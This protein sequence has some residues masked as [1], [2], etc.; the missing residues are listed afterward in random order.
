M[1]QAF[2][3]LG[4]AGWELVTI[5]DKVSN[6]LGGMEKGFAIFKREVAPEDPEPDKWASWEYADFVGRPPGERRR[7]GSQRVADAC[8]AQKHDRCE[9]PGCVC[10][11]HGARGAG[12]T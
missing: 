8:R 6:W 1:A 12:M 11:Y 10:D 5:H 3:H 4:S 2:G 7:L 9:S